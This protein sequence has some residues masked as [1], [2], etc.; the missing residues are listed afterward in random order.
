MFIE[1]LQRN[2][3]S[4]K[5]LFED[6]VL[7]ASDFIV[8]VGMFLDERESC[9]KTEQDIED[10]MERMSLADQIVARLKLYYD[11]CEKAYTELSNNYC[12][13][14]MQGKCFMAYTRIKDDNDFILNNMASVK[15]KLSKARGV[16]CVPVEP[17]EEE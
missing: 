10:V 9:V 8:E 11:D 12:E 3:T 2:F 6:V 16:I 13:C 14:R 4:A 17:G 15:R 5:E 7:D 1:D